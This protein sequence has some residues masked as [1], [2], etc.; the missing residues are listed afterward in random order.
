MPKPY[1]PEND[2]YDLLALDPSDPDNY[3]DEDEDY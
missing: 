1:D 2:D 3:D